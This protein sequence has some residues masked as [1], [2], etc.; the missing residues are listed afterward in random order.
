[1][2]YIHER[3]LLS[4]E[5]IGNFAICNNMDRLGVW[6]GGSLIAQLVKNLPAIQKTLVQSLGWKD[7]LEWGMATPSSILVWGIPWTQEPGG[8]QSIGL[9]RVGHN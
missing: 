2:W 4:H 5:K 3:I 1:M 7:P 8:L 6:G 9:H